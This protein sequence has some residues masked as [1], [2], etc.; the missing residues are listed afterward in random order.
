MKSW[1]RAGLLGGAGIVGLTLILTLFEIPS[2]I[3]AYLD[4]IIIYPAVGAL[5]TVWSS[6]SPSLKEGA[7][8]AALSG[9]VAGGIDLLHTLLISISIMW[10]SDFYIN[11]YPHNMILFLRDNM[12]SQFFS[13]LNLPLLIGIMVA[14]LIIATSTGALGGWIYVLWKGKGNISTQRAA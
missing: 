2:H 6:T 10:G 9:L 13:A 14:S 7:G 3:P 8:M 1:L 11:Y 5:S 12:A 4:W